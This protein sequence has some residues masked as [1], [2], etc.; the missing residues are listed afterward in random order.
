MTLGEDA[1][2]VPVV[3]TFD[4]LLSGYTWNGVNAAGRG[5]FVTYSFDTRASAAFAGVYAD[6]FLASFQTFTAAEQAIARQA[7]AAW[8]DISGLTLFEVPAGQGDIRL[9][10]YDFRYAPLDSEDSL[11]FAYTPFVDFG[12]GGREEEF[13]GDI[14][15]ATGRATFEVLLHEIGHALGLKHP[16]EGA[17]TLDPGLDNLTSTVMTYNTVGGPAVAP[18]GL[19]VLAIQHLYGGPLADGAQAASWSWDATR[20]VLTQSGGAGADSLTGVGVEDRIRGGAGSDYVLGRGGDDVIDGEDGADTLAGGAGTDTIIGGAGADILDGDD[21]ADSLSG[22]DGDDE[23]WGLAGA[24]VLTGDAGDD[25]LNGGTGA[26]R[27]LGGAG[28]DILVVVDGSSVVDGGEG[29]DALWLAAS[30][31]AG[32]A[33]SYASLTRDGGAYVGIETVV[34]FGN[35]GADTLL[36]GALPD[37][38]AGGAG[39]DTLSGDGGDDLLFGEAGDDTVSGGAGGDTVSGGEGASYLRGDDG[40]DSLTGGG[41]FDDINGNAGADSAAGGGGDDWVV[42]GRGDD[43]LSGDGGADIVYGNLGNDTGEGG[44]GADLLRG[45]Q[46]DDV[47]GGGAGDDWLSGDR[48]DDS[49]TGG[50]GADVFHTFAEAGIDR[51]FDFNMDEGDRVMVDAET[52]YSVTQVGADTVIDMVGGGQMVLV[53]VSLS[54]LTGAWI[55]GA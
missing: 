18:G 24:D 9:G 41:A 20:L 13:G 11:G 39:A 19:D 22:G 55:F 32:A 12:G 52:R 54:T 47:L 43:R 53:G 6:A 27:L 10:T 23:V 33:L 31:P 34:L 7:L 45:G 50:S 28:D 26:N 35:L 46:G 17:V 36:G 21:G 14:F 16:F 51:V 2:R 5:A 4:A 8:A 3:T 1:A 42:G 49:L 25:T 30:G 29:Y 37:V 44:A 48:G 38:L 15:I 40:D